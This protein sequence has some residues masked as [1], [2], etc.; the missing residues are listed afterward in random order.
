MSGTLKSRTARA[1]RRH[2]RSARVEYAV[3]LS[4]SPAVKVYGLL[5]TGT[6]YLTKL[7]EINFHAFPLQSVEYGWKHGPCE[8]SRKIQFVFLTKNPYSW[9]RSFWEWEKIHQRTQACSLEEFMLQ[10]ISHPEL[11]RK[12]NAATPV[13]AWNVSLR[14]WL[15]L[16]NCD[17]VVFL[18]Y[19]SL[20]GDFET[21]MQVIQDKLSLRARHSTYHNLETRAD[22]WETPK[23][24]KELKTAYYRQGKFINDFSDAEIQILHDRI[25]P[26][27]ASKFGYEIL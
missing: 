26:A 9:I 16:E 2:Y 27:I 11:R 18:R 7:L 3:H 17:N 5:R 12:W 6:N 13:D 4:P 10:E 15:E 23:P 8:Y 25:D 22:N 21:Q 19:E 24:R 20:L 1:L 14:S